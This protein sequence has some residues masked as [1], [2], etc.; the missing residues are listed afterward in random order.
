MVGSSA[1][2]AEG[3]FDAIPHAILFEKALNIIPDHCWV[4]MV[5]YVV[6]FY[7]CTG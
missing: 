2:D 4:I 3:A 6:L 1:L 5:K 7:V